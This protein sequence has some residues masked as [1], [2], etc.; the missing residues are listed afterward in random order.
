V[1]L[2]GGDPGYPCLTESLTPSQ[3]RGL[4]TRA[5]IRAPVDGE[6]ITFDMESSNTID[7]VKAKIQHKKEL[8][9]SSRPSLA[10]RLVSDP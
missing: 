2:V 8:Q 6:I 1:S 4:L 5:Q 7:N 10:R 9:S 3:A